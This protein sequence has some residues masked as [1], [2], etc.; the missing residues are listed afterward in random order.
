MGKLK[1]NLK[2]D[3]QDIVTL[4]DHLEYHTKR[5]TGIVWIRQPDIQIAGDG[6]A[7]FTITI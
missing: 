7:E 5:I 6:E 2:G 1:L 3:V 4:H